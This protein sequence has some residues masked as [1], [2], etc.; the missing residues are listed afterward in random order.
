[1]TPRLLTAALITALGLPA[2]AAESG[3]DDV[4]REVARMRADYESRIQELEN[5]LAQAEGKSAAVDAKAEEARRTAEQAA[6]NKPPESASGFNPS[7]SVILNGTATMSKKDPSAYRVPGFALG[8][9]GKPIERGFALG[10]SEVNFSA[11]VDQ[12]LYGSLTLAFTRENTVEV[13]E[14]F[15]QSMSLPW[16]FTL[17]GGRFKSGIGTLNEQHAHTWDFADAP[18]PYLLMLGPQYGDDGVQVRWL[19]PTKMF[20]ELGAEGMRGGQFPGQGV[21]NKG[22]GAWSVFAHVGDD[23]GKGGEGGSWRLGLSR[24]N[25]H[26]RDRKTNS[27]ND[28]F[29]GDNALHIVDAVYKWAPDGNFADRYVKLQGEYFHRTESGLFND[30]RDDSTQQ[31]YYAQ[32]VWQF[33][34]RWR[35]GARYDRAWGEI[36]S[37]L[38]GT[39]LDPAGHVA[40]RKSLMLDYSTS[41][42]GRFRLQGNIDNSGPSADH[43]VILQYTVSLGAHGAHPY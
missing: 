2:Q 21:S 33:M 31:G 22:M 12:A 16:G 36:N 7:V 35:V 19:A 14:A 15:I 3:L 6:K 40:S 27:D 37:E 29:K 20:V 28:T 23:I 41:E 25:T 13:E 42:F 1:M 32:A 26:A 43:Q 11:N 34:P 8:D 5:R 30:L 10:E 24:L 9:E 39:T 4:R 38:A 17:K 18:L